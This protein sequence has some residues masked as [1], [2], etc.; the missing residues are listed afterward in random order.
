M[1]NPTTPN[2]PAAGGDRAGTPISRFAY[3]NWP[4]SRR[5]VI[6]GATLVVV[7]GLIALPI[8][9]LTSSGNPIK[10]HSALVFTGPTTTVTAT[11]AAPAP[12]T[13]EAPATT[14]PAATTTT[15]LAPARQPAPTTST[16]LVCRNSYNPAC[17]PFRWDPAPAP[18]GAWTVSLQYSPKAPAVGDLVTFT[19]TI[20]DPN[21]SV[22]TCG[23]VSF[24]AG[25]PDQNCEAQSASC[26][27]R[28]GPWD[29][30]AKQADSVTTE[31]TYKY[32]NPG[33]YTFSV[34]YPVG[35]PC[36][37]PYQAQASASQSVTV[38]A[39]PSSTPTGT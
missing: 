13:T 35:N 5:Q 32:Q 29:P 15:T 20:S 39:A 11:A 30:P 6:A 25:G 8:I 26:Q 9:A 37:D 21:T 2:G 4:R 24:G 3:R 14:V 12:T 7:A 38:S 18:A 17:G 34:A 27:T 16:T 36:Y 33:T 22:Y 28:Y 31:Y 10:S 23:H 1:D 19:V